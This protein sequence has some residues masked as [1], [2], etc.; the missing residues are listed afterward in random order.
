[1]LDCPIDD[2][3]TGGQGVEGQTPVSLKS[4][5]A[6]TKDT[7]ITGT[8]GKKWLSKRAHTLSELLSPTEDYPWEEFEGPPDEWTLSHMAFTPA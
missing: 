5:Q 8:S 6:N 7:A 3:L 1:M 2:R 4:S